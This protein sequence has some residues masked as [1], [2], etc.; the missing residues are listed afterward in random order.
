MDPDPV[1]TRLEPV[2][3]SGPAVLR[4]FRPG[5]EVFVVPERQRS[6]HGEPKTRQL[7]VWIRTS[8]IKP[9]LLLPAAA[10]G[11]PVRERRSSGCLAA[12][13]AG[14]HVCTTLPLLERFPNR[15]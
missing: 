9:V 14:G 11:P 12:K 13:T 8:Q 10:A 2:C 7:Q 4:T 5:S 1:Q 15:K 6:T 3:G